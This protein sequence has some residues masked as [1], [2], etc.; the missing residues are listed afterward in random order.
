MPLEINVKRNRKPVKLIW[1]DLTLNVVLTAALRES[2]PTM[3]WS[4][5]YPTIGDIEP[6][7][8]ANVA[9]T[10]VYYLGT[11]SPL[12]KQGR[13]VL[14]QFHMYEIPAR[15]DPND[16][17]RRIDLRPGDVIEMWRSYS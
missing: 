12:W 6:P 17:V 13:L 9:D 1:D 11:D 5:K 14:K 10:G 16:I 2:D 8:F 3:A 4:E 15:D 7:N